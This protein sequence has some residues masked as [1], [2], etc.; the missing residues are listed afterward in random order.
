M[1]V[2]WNNSV[3]TRECI[4]SLLSQQFVESEI[5]LV[6]N[7]SDK[8]PI[9]ELSKEFPTIHYIRS[10]RNL[11]FAG[12]TNLG[13]RT[14]LETDAQSFLIINNDTKA[15][16][17]MLSELKNALF[18]E[19]SGLTAPLIYYYDSP[20]EIW[21]SGGKINPCLLMPLDS[22]SRNETLHAPV[23]RSFVSGCCCLIKRELLEK[24][25]LFDERFFLYFED[26]DFSM[27]VNKAG[28]K[29]M[30]IPSAKLY[31]KV[32]KSS[33]GESS[34]NERYHYALSSGIYYRKYLNIF[35]AIPIILFRLGSAIV[36]SLRLL[37][38]GKIKV[39]KNY[40]KGLYQGWFLKDKP[41]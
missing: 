5:F 4:E 8:E 19:D 29:M 36:T 25:G 28:F 13:L 9:D 14:A 27:R 10:E 1:I 6:D 17:T 40:L 2:A 34:D 33:G 37:F 39:L 7:G 11:G 15:A 22:H 21:S 23:E 20:Q 24:V 18:T 30:I 41:N 31:H 38:K 12:G 26:L 3:D 16:P 32:S 35:N